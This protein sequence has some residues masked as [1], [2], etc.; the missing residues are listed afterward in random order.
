M[1]LGRGGAT[2]ANRM[3]GRFMMGR[4]VGQSTPRLVR[5]VAAML[6]LFLAGAAAAQ[7][8]QIAV[9]VSLTGIS[10]IVGVP[11]MN[12]ARM[13]VEDA[14]ARTGLPPIILDAHD[15]RSDPAAAREIAR[16]V[17]AGQAL[18]VMGPGITPAAV[19]AG[20]IYGE[21]GIANIVPHAHG[22]PE[23]PTTFRIVFGP[24][25]MGAAMANHLV[26]VLGQR[27]AVMLFRD[28]PFGRPIA[29]GFRAAAARLGLDAAMHGFGDAAAGAALATRLAGDSAGSAI[30]LAMVEPD[31]KAVLVALRRAGAA[32]PII[33]ASPMAT[34]QFAAY[35]RDEPE[36]RRS[37]GHF[38]DGVLA[39]SPIMLDS[40]NAETLAFAA[41]YRARFG[42]EPL[43]N[44]VQGYDAMRLAIAALRATAG[45]A[46]RDA[47][48]RAV[49]EW[50]RAIDS[51]ARA[52]PSLTG[53]LWFEGMGSR[54]QPARIGRFTGNV[55]ESAPVQLVPVTL[56]TA[57]EIVSG[58]LVET[59]PGRW[60]RR[61]Q[62]VH[63]GALVNEI[64]RLDIAQSSFTADLY[65]W[66][67]FV[68]T[69]GAEADPAEIEFPDMVRGNFD[70]ARPAALRRLDDGTTYQLWRL[71]GEF[72]NDFDLRR[73][74]FDRQN[75][76][77]RMFNARASADSIV[78][79]RDRRGAAAPLPE[80][81][82]HGLGSSV[83]D[84]AFRN[85]T[86]WEPLRA[87]QLRDNLVT[88]SAL[89]D[90][91]LVG[92]ERVRELS[93]FRI[94]I[95][96][97]RLSLVTLA[98]SLLPLGIMT[99]IM[100]AA[101]WFPHALV[102][103]KITVAITAALSGAVLLAALNSQLGAV[104]Y[105]LAIEYV[106]YVYFALSLLCILAVLAAERQRA[107]GFARFAGWTEAATR[108]VFVLAVGGTAAAIWLAALR[109]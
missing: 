104:G 102:K 17:A 58:R 88:Q 56:P 76:A 77:I 62:V 95:G 46:E 91:G 63:A 65:L 28:N 107:A 40:G 16:S 96:L 12:A 49:V 2:L 59:G 25:E 30:A 85:L 21:A 26:H 9:P 8:L 101:L 106:F 60:S 79:V 71:R 29:E 97:R 72:K 99:L 87:G 67:R 3:Q 81:A 27:R 36:E 61:Q 73:Y 78:Y 108:G 83:A 15:D 48:R 18:V 22:A 98:K 43:W 35:F 64:P 92:A 47:R 33:G 109:W 93:G 44:A 14:N 69:P 23:A 34:E 80:A 10:A 6:G 55:V 37:P 1:T 82:S 86:Q 4:S 84:D 75:L 11:V 100:L 74:P 7:P 19:L 68:A 90:P 13:A 89:G 105:T 66:L 5:G 32:G 31:A 51:S 41:R 103:E 50:L 57:A 94:E 52:V 53:P 70:A 54:P 38:L 45:V 39:A 20:P 24:A 42:E